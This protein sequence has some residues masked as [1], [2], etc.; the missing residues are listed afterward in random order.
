MGFLGFVHS[1]LH[2]VFWGFH[3]VFNGG[4]W[5]EDARLRIESIGGLLVMADCRAYHYVPPKNPI[6]TQ[7]ISHRN[8]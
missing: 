2:E 5:Q 4:G 3:R 7:T 8:I 6:E 1:R